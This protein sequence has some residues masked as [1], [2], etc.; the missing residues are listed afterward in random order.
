MNDKDM[1]LRCSVSCLRWITFCSFGAS[2]K[3]NYS[4]MYNSIIDYTY[5][6]INLAINHVNNTLLIKKSHIITY[7]SIIIITVNSIC[8]NLQW[9]QVVGWL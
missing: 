2:N 9:L 5:N 6:N 3:S 7:I 8:E 4:N 1:L